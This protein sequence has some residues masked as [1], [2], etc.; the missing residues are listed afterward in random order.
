M[1][2]PR[3][4]L[5]IEDDPDH[6]ELIAKS[7]AGG[8]DRYCVVHAGTLAEARRVLR[9]QAV[10]LTL[11]DWRLPDGEASELLT[12]GDSW[13][14]SAIIVMTSQGSEQAAVEVMRRG[15][16]DYVVK[17]PQI[18]A[19]M[20][21]VVERALRE[22]DREA[23]R[24]RME[25]ELRFRSLMLDQ[26]S[27]LVVAADT[28]GHIVYT[29][30]ALRRTIDMPETALLGQPIEDLGRWFEGAASMRH[31]LRRLIAEDAWRGHVTLRSQPPPSP[32]FEVRASPVRDAAGNLVAI[33]L[34][35]TDV[36]AQLQ[37]EKALQE[38][39]HFLQ[40]ILDAVPVAIYYKDPEGR[41][42]GCNRAF[43]EFFNLPE[44]RVQGRQSAQIMPPDSARILDAATAPGDDPAA[45]SL[46]E[47]I[48]PNTQGHPRSVLVTRAP[49]LDSAN[50][51]RGHIA[52]LVD[53]TERKQAEEDIHLLT[54]ELI[55]AQESERL[56]IALDLHDNVAQDLAVARIACDSVALPQPDSTQARQGLE[57][58]RRLIEA[59]IAN[60][61]HLSHAL[62]PP[63][64]DE[65]G[66]VHTIEN[67][68]QEFS[69][70]NSIAIDFQANGIENLPIGYEA[71][72]HIYRLVQESLNNVRKHASATEVK[73][74]L[75]ASSP[76]IILR[77]HDNG[78]GFPRTPHTA[79]GA[80]LSAAAGMGLKGMQE[81]VSLLQGKM[82]LQSRPHSGAEILI[83]IPIMEIHD[84]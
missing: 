8:E 72:I 73:I 13:R 26:I 7:L 84:A 3:R 51:P 61:R 81:R 43:R 52:T 53:I 46:R 4:I 1:I 77:I 71:R 45:I 42:L 80:A 65:L 17:S 25:Q 64:L 35:Y 57:R 10:D 58:I 37:T 69:Q 75:L 66:L 76:H 22:R 18:F 28:D 63:G 82:T 62:R 29:N 16:L 20:R 38:Q 9:E 50:T 60:I 79:P 36:T 19:D 74:R 39:F 21:H 2:E 31:V 32:V 56:R 27:D 44:E 41:Y 11:A 15:A 24:R 47:A 12:N 70:T 30:A 14:A 5:L 40:S 34:T 59:S 83:S 68:C 78:L 23:V 6:A 33:C 49:L 48:L 67:L 55:R 54:R